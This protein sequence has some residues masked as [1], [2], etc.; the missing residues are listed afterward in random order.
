MA[1]GAS[2]S[3]VAT[4]YSPGGYPAKPRPVEGDSGYHHQQHNDYQHN[5]GHGIP[6][7]HSEWPAVR[8]SNSSHSVLGDQPSST[9]YVHTIQVSDSPPALKS[10]SSIEDNWSL[11]EG[12]GRRLHSHDSYLTDNHSDWQDSPR[13]LQGHMAH[14]PPG[15]RTP[16]PQQYKYVIR[17]PYNQQIRGYPSPYRH[18]AATVRH[19]SPPTRYPGQPVG[20]AIYVHGPRSPRSPG[21]VLVRGPPPAQLQG[22][23]QGHMQGGQPVRQMVY[24]H[25]GGYATTPR[26]VVY[27]PPRATTPPASA[28]RLYIKN[29]TVH[30]NRSPSRVS[31]VSHASH[32][33]SSGLV[34]RAQGGARNPFP[35]MPRLARSNSTGDLLDDPV[36]S[37]Y[38]TLPKDF[39]V[40][41][42]PISPHSP[43]SPGYAQSIHL[44]TDVPPLQPPSPQGHFAQS[45]PRAIQTR[46]EVRP[47]GVVYHGHL[48]KVKVP[49]YV[50]NVDD[51][52]A[53]LQLSKLR[54]HSEPN[55]A[56]IDGD[57]LDDNVVHEV[58]S[59]PHTP[60]TPVTKALS[61]ITTGQDPP[62]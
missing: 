5:S 27:V 20:Q 3:L 22:N 61:D 32:A 46:P 13:D 49:R 7:S 54:Y 17:S 45:I 15:P 16:G 53:K 11:K 25:P 29:S 57:N 36:N 51:E 2:G 12:R 9:R 48:V 4:I 55:L 56:D 8:R 18:A 30:L 39:A 10:P 40:Q 21:P 37:T 43:V 52:A 26:Q 28:Q 1:E 24:R 6:H 23:V 60:T 34:A 33:S 62:R 19:H 47:D 58:G 50:V 35:T 31:H 44:S 14:R 38:Q 42:E 59:P 41:R